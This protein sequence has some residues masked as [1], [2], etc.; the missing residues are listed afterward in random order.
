MLN[1]Q[2]IGLDSDLTGKWLCTSCRPCP[3]CGNYDEV[4]PDRTGDWFCSNCPEGEDVERPTK[5][6]P[7]QSRG[8]KQ[9]AICSK[10]FGRHE[11]ESRTCGGKYLSSQDINGIPSP[12]YVSATQPPADQED[13]NC[14]RDFLVGSYI[15]LCPSEESF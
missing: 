11:R 13:E 14:T 7:P 2:F 3:I 12:D 9:C 5:L 10:S 15:P 1:T 4:S 6:A 8:P